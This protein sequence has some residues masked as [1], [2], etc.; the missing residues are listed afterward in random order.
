MVD[1]EGLNLLPEKS[2]KLKELCAYFLAEKI[3]FY[4]SNNNWNRNSRYRYYVILTHYDKPYNFPVF[5]SPPV[6]QAKEQIIVYD[7]DTKERIDIPCRAQVMIRIKGP[8]V[9]SAIQAFVREGHMEVSDI[10]KVHI[11]SPV[12]DFP[13]I[14]FIC[15]LDP[16]QNRGSVKS[17]QEI[18]PKW[19]L[20]TKA[21]P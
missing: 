1:I 7:E 5:R 13:V 12:P 20:N 9:G 16:E 4:Y 11:A 17:T 8:R 2:E 3:P 19:S 21:Y 14:T 6:S 18:T 15:Y 10:R